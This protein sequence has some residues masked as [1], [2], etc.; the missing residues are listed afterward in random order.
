MSVQLVDGG[1]VA[2]AAYVGA[3]YLVTGIFPFPVSVLLA[4]LI[5]AATAVGAAWV[6]RRTLNVMGPPKGS[7]GMP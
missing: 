6:E 4:A 1:E 5:Y 7:R 2:L 3:V